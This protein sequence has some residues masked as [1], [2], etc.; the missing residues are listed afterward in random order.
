MSMG[1]TRKQHGLLVYINSRVRESGIPPSFDEMADAVDL[2]SKSG[3]HRLLTSLEKRGYVRRMP[4]RARALEVLAMPADVT[5]E[6]AMSRRQALIGTSAPR[7]AK[8][9]SIQT[10]AVPVLGRLTTGTPVECL[11]H[12]IAETTFPIA[13]CADTGE[14]YAVYI[15]GDSMVNA[16]ILDGDVAIFEHRSQCNTGEIILALID[17]CEVV[18]RRF[19]RRGE[20]VAL[21]SANPAYETRLYGSH[22]VRVQGRIV[23]LQRR[24]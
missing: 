19:R 10:I 1:L 4:G 24:Y 7:S 9:E 20:L 18:L 15:V 17:N 2:K 23:G 21:E 13:M 14:Y 16:G 12:K 8:A 3:V 11:Q 6:P 22:R 5:A